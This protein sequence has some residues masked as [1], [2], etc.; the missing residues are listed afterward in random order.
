MFIVILL[1][2]VVIM[3]FEIEITITNYKIRRIEHLYFLKLC[4]LIRQAVGIRHSLIHDM[5]LI[6]I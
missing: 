6:G 2:L 5:P 1:I 4:F 3:L